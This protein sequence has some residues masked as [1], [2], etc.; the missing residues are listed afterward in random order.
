MENGHSATQG[1]FRKLLGRIES[2]EWGVGTTLPSERR[3]MEELGVSRV[4]LREALSM[5][6]A[7]GALETRHG[8][9]T[10]VRRIDAG[11]LAQLFPL[12]FRME[13]QRSFEQVFEL[14]LAIEC[15]TAR[16]AAQRRTEDDVRALNGL[17]LRFREAQAQ[18]LEEAVELDLAFHVRIAEATGNTLFA[19]LLRTLAPLVLYGMV[20]SCKDDPVRRRRGLDSHEAIAEAIIDKDP[21]R[22]A[23]EM[24]AHLR[25][26]ASRIIDSVRARPVEG[27]V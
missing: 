22:A 7:L 13:G 1:V 14:R 17:V 4:A 10:T 5:L 27:G 15:R 19:V 20:E 24:E 9:G 2:G 21:D 23:V 8:S 11:V 25:Y 12:M 6:R 3:L 18:T 16:L 26:S